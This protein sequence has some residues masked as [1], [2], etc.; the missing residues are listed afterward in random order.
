MVAV[1]SITWSVGE[2]EGKE[3]LP[4]HGMFHI[5]FFTEYSK[6]VG[7]RAMEFSILNIIFNISVNQQP[8]H[9]QTLLK[10]LCTELWVYD[11]FKYRKNSTICL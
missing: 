9:S 6:E 7:F 11:T 2:K 4:S 5:C 8:H 10:P 1:Y 3:N